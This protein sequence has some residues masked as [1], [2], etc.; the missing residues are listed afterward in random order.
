M[1]REK[2][3]EDLHFKGK[4]AGRAL[5][6]LTVNMLAQLS[7]DEWVKDPSKNNSQLFYYFGLKPSLTTILCHWCLTNF[8]L[9]K[10]KGRKEERERRAPF[11]HTVDSIRCS[12]VVHSAQCHLGILPFYALLQLLH[13]L[14]SL[15]QYSFKQFCGN[16]YSVSNAGMCSNTTVN[17]CGMK[18]TLS[19]GPDLVLLCF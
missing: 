9:K 3:R 13:S 10:K 8:P 15:R 5:L 7:S 16:I 1:W 12:R 6:L 2:A 17:Q 4:E 11:C 19:G 18:M 14:Y